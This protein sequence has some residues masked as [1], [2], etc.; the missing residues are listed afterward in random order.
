MRAARLALAAVTIAAAGAGC[1][2]RPHATAGGSEK[3]QPRSGPA[4]V[5]LDVSGGLPEKEAGGLLGPPP[6]RRRS[7]DSILRV[8]EATRSDKDTKGYYVRFGSASFGTARAEELG[9]I[10]AD[11]RAKIPVYCHAEG[12][13][14]SSILAA[15]RG[16][17]KISLAPS[18]EVETVGIAAQVDLSPTSSSAKSSTS[19][20]TSCRSASSRAPRSRSRATGRAPRRASRSRECSSTCGRRGS[21]GFAQGRSGHAGVREAVEDGPFSAPVAKD[22][23]LV[24]AIAYEDDARAEAKKA[25]SA[26]RD[27]VRYG[28]GS[29]KADE[30]PDLDDVLKVFAGDDSSTPQVMVLRADR[31]H[32]DGRRRQLDR[33]DDGITEKALVRRIKRV[34]DDDAV[35]AVVLRIDSPGGSALASDLI[36]HEL[37]KLRKKKPLV[38]SVGDMAASGGYYLASTGN[39]IFAEP[40]SIVGSI[41]V[42]G[43]KIRNRRHAR[44]GRRPRRDVPREEGGRR[45]QGARRVRVAVRAVGRRDARARAGVDDGHLRSLPHARGRGP[46]DERRRNRASRPKDASSAAPKERGAGSSTRSAGSTRRF[47]ARR[48]SAGCRATRSCACSPRRPGS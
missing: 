7:F 4:L 15:A 44:A 26:V 14:N 36:W 45:G 43:G 30:G 6:G 33:R 48:S 20:S 3:A 21:T 32:L 42:V 19:T 24:D 9:D 1:E 38:V 16:C 29:G 47:G 39:E 8:L 27:V 2:G 23:G 41:G 37:M 13:G 40:T 28:P 34:A 11:I 31:E 5:V 46:Q 25:V 18:G 12:L 17:T 10:L 22:R 35:R